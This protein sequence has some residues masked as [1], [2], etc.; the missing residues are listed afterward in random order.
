MRDNSNSAWKTEVTINEIQFKSA[1]DG[2]VTI[3]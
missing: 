2:K 3:E 1:R